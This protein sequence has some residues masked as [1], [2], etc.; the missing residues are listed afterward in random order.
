MEYGICVQSA[1]AVRADPSHRSE[2]VTQILFGELYRI[3]GKEHSWIKIQLAFDDYEGWIDILQATV[4]G[5]E[6]FL[7]LMNS[8]T[9]TTIDLMQL[10]S[11]ENAR[12]MIPVVMGSSLPAYDESRIRIGQDVFY[13]E[14]E[15]SEFQL[16]NAGTRHE[17]TLKTRQQL[18]EDAM[19]YLNAP[20]LW[21]GRTPFGIDCSGFVQMVYKLQGMKLRRDAS[22]QALQGEIISLHAESEGGDLAFFDNPEGNIN[23]VGMII[24]RT[25]I[26]HSSGQVHIDTLDHE[27]IYNARLQKYTHKLRLIKRIVGN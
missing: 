6:E 19:L 16:H 20:Y 27:G 17:N 11:H 13:Y 21:G 10:I 14:G 3:T 9:S 25:R 7:R 12:S 26:I 15:V 18:I 1:T 23:H 2:M 22:Q 24:D 8:T 4:I 5:E